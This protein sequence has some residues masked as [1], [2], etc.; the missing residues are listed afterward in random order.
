MSFFSFL[1]FFVNT[2]YSE[3]FFLK[4][5]FFTSRI[6]G[7]LATQPWFTIHDVQTDR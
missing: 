3:L 2:W 5:F 6:A 1:S 4:I 7:T